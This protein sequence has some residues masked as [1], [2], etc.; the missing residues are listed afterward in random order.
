VKDGR[1]YRFNVSQNIIKGQGAFAVHKP[2]D[3]S[4]REAPKFTKAAVRPAKKA[5]RDDGYAVVRPGPIK[6]YDQR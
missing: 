2:G 1:R 5:K 4:V 6:T 3:L